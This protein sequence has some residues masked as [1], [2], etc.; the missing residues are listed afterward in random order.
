MIDFVNAWLNK[1]ATV[2]FNV[3]VALGIVVVATL[4]KVDHLQS[5]IN[6]SLSLSVWYLLVRVRDLEKR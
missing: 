5:L 4:L 1:P 2:L 6:L 3:L